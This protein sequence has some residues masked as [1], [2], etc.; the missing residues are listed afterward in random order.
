MSA[1]IKGSQDEQVKNY[2]EEFQPQENYGIP[3]PEVGAEI[4]AQSDKQ[5]ARP[6]CS[7]TETTNEGFTAHRNRSNH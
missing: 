5:E 3:A 2:F 7:R 1:E 6:Q 4:Q